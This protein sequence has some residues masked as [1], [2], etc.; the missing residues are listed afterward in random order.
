VAEFAAGSTIVRRDVFEGRVWSACPG[1]VLSDDGGELVFGYWPGVE[2]V[3][4]VSW[5][6]W[7][8]TGDARRRSDGLA[9]LAGRRWA[10]GRWSWRWT[11]VV[12][13]LASG[14]G[15]SVDSFFDAGSGE[16][17]CW[18][19]NFERPYV[20]T[21]I[22]VDTFDLLVDLVVRPDLTWS[23]KDEGEYAHACRLGV[24]PEA[25]QAAVTAA[26]DEA[27]GLIESQAGPFADP[28]DAWHPDEG[29]PTPE[30]PPGMDLA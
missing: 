11:N 20:R 12:Q 27:I 8:T 30:L 2:S 18:Y 7:L 9:D 22:G 13:A 25:D 19:V 28:D 1:R 21:A 14:R 29:W 3:V 24:I 6:D 17:L 4:P 5:I 16:R 26:R 15:F 23:W 10:L